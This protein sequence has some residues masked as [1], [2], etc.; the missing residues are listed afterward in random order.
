MEKLAEKMSAEKKEL[1]L[2]EC[3]E[4]LE[5]EIVFGKNKSGFKV[6]TIETAGGKTYTTIKAIVGSYKSLIKDKKRYIFVTKFKEEALR[7]TKDINEGAGEVIAMF[8]TPDKEFNDECCSDNFFECTK[9]NTLVLTHS[10]YC[11]ISNHIIDRHKLYGE[12]IRKYKTLIIDE[13]INPVKESFFE[14]NIKCSS[15]ETILKSF[16]L[17]DLATK[18]RSY[19]NPLMIQLEE[20]YSDNQLHRLELDYDRAK[21]DELYLELYEGVKNIISER[22]KDYRKDNLDYKCSREN[23]L[24]LLD[25]VYMTYEC[26]DNNVALIHPHSGIYSYNYKFGYIALDN[27]IWLDASASFN[28]MY[29]IASIF[30]VVNC[31]REI[32]HSESEFIYHNL[33]TSTSKKNQNENFRKNISEYVR[34]NHQGKKTLILSK[35][36]ENIS[37]QEEED[38]LKDLENVEFLNFEEMRGVDDYK[39]YEVCYYIHTYRFSPAYYVFCYE[40][41]TDEN[42]Q[43]KELIVSN[44]KLNSKREWGFENEQLYSLMIS[45]MASS[46]YQGLK[47][48]QRNRNPKAIF[49]VFTSSVQALSIVL[50]QLNGIDKENF[51]IADKGKQTDIEKTIEFIEKRFEE[52]SGSWI[53]IESSEVCELLN[54]SP[55]NWKKIW[56]SNENFKDYINKKRISQRKLKSKDGKSNRKVNWIIKY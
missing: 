46:M 33:N 44:R 48:I 56:S 29:Q 51:V 22:F 27:N 9:V 8:Y 18:F 53:K 23:L 5:Y 14:F 37:L 35:K 31:P 19:I 21:I 15:W 45:D 41:F 26:I 34:N 42:L 13:E 17:Y 1:S 24:K 50:K 47:R 7:V 38:Y 30:E 10:M 20:N 36:V 32:D 52:N 54:I 3:L 25:D 16:S 40:Y 11:K 49:E 39:E 6:F 12:I 43:D 4:D 28:T 2:Q 55:S